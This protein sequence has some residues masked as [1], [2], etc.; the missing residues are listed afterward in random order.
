MTRKEVASILTIALL[1]LAVVLGVG[2]I[3]R[4]NTPPMRAP[5]IP[6]G[7]QDEPGRTIEL[8]WLGPTD[9]Y[10][11]EPEGWIEKGLQERFN[12]ELKPIFLD[13]NQYERKRPLMFATGDVP[14]VI[15]LNDPGP[16]QRDVHHGFL[17]EVPY[18]LL[19]K[20]APT[21]VQLLNEYA[22][23]AWLYANWK[24]RNFGLPTKYIG[25]LYPRPGIWRAD[26]LIRVG[27]TNPDGSADVPETL[28]EFEEAFR[29]FSQGD[30]DGDGVAGNTYGL[31]ADVSKWWWSS[32]SDIFGAFGCTPFDWQVDDDGQVVWGGVSG[33]AR[34]ALALLRRWYAEGLIDPA[35]TTDTMEQDQLLRKF[36][37]GKIGYINYAARFDRFDADQ[38]GALIN[39]MRKRHPDAEIV[40]AWF[41]VGPDGHRGG[42]VWSSAGNI[43]CFGKHVAD[44]PAKAVR[45]LN[46]LE[47]LL[48][49]EIA[50]ALRLDAEAPIV[51]SECKWGRRGIHWQWKDLAVGPRSGQVFLPP[52]DEKYTRA[53]HLLSFSNGFYGLVSGGPETQ[54]RTKEEAALHFR[55]TYQK[56]E[57]ALMNVFGKSDVLPS[58]GDYLK[59]L[60]EMQMATYTKIIIGALPL[61]AF[62]D[63]VAE[64][65]RR[66][67]DVMTAEAR[68]ML[69]T[70]REIYRRL[71]IVARDAPPTE[72][73]Q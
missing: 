5:A 68:D 37:D 44:D 57:W 26:W 59:D 47:T 15:W 48:K 25:G 41:P 16:L 6:P 1:A 2:E 29:R 58:A 54:D 36:T 43:I 35:F 12:V 61:D 3:Y 63:F 24:G 46:M 64:W 53:R 38:T 27:L 42:R 33:R 20:H 8:T 7:A 62:D 39:I 49:E 31:S 11:G 32:F 66:G 14:D 56:P 40:P 21:C 45:V 52:Y 65:I 10:N 55:E 73:A 72:E 71:G 30:P 60:R 17:A 70:R 51:G 18:E 9:F 69:N 50:G 28:A 19:Q 23:H 22:P 4:A 67:G 13:G 34:R